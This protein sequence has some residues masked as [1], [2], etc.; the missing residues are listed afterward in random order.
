[1]V[2]WAVDTMRDGLCGETKAATLILVLQWLTHLS[3]SCCQDCKF[4]ERKC[5]PN[6]NFIYFYITEII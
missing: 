5:T 3:A 6:T 1:M 4:T 2:E